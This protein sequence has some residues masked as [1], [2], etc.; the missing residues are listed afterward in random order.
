MF[1]VIIISIISLIAIGLANSTYKQIVLASIARDSQTAFYM[2]DTIVECLE[3]QDLVIDMFSPTYSG[4]FIF[5]C[6]KD[7]SN[8]DFIM[9]VENASRSGNYFTIK[10]DDE[11]GSN[12]CFSGT[13]AKSSGTDAA[14]DAVTNT[15]IRGS[16]YNICNKN[17]TRTVERTLKV[18]Y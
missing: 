15:E 8:K 6:G 7:T 12:P 2:A 9:R 16:G 17:N 10:L 1:T 18:N 3:Y 4:S 13:V 5:T 14:G 11:T